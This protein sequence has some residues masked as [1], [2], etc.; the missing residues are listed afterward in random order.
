MSLEAQLSDELGYEFKSQGEELRTPVMPCDLRKTQQSSDHNPK[1]RPKTHVLDVIVR[2]VRRGV[3][4]KIMALHLRKY[5]MR[6]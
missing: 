4:I 3:R 1:Q 6:E 5:I 2:N